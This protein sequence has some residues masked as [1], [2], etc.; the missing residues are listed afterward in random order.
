MVYWIEKY[1]VEKW[2]EV[3]FNMVV[4]FVWYLLIYYGIV[5]EVY[6]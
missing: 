4:F 2:L 3:F 6:V 5:I 1:G